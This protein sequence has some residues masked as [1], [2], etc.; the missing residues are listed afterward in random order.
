MN[1]SKN[2]KG[3]SVI[4]LLVAVS[5]FVT[6]SA[7]LIQSV[8]QSLGTSQKVGAES[9]VRDNLNFAGDVVVRNLRNA[10]SITS[11]CDGSS[12][13]SI[14]YLDQNSVAGS[15]TCVSGQSPYLGSGSTNA[16]LTSDDVII[17]SCRITCTQSGTTL[18]P[19]VELLLG[20]RLVTSDSRLESSLEVIKRV[21]LRTY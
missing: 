7:V 11:V 20:G 5:L 15:F 10:K 9:A 16:R 6:L 13:T 17:T 12:L 4:E 18:P 1:K 19:T 2:N 8:V 14:S 3:F 21:T